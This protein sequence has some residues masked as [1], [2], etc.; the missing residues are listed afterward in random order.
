MHWIKEAFEKEELTADYVKCEENERDIMTK[1]VTEHLQERFSKRLRNGTLRIHKQWNSIVQSVDGLHR[2]T[3]GE[4]VEQSNSNINES[5]ESSGTNIRKYGNN[6][7]R[8]M[9]YYVE[10]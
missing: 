2:D 10:S 4:A 7:D 3:I 1:N 5:D 6:L 8:Q 9:Y